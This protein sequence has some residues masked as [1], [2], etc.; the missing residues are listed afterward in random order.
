MIL[1]GYLSTVNVQNWCGH[2][3]LNSTPIW[4]QIE[5]CSLSRARDTPYPLDVT[6]KD[7]I[8]FLLPLMVAVVAFLYVCLTRRSWGHSQPKIVFFFKTWRVAIKYFY[9]P[10]MV[11]DYS[12]SMM[13][14]K[15]YKK[16]AFFRFYMLTLLKVLLHT[17]MT[18]YFW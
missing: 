15:K 4:P 18:G 11:Y 16:I 3:T 5:L 7:N 17:M 2:H 12:T 14:T 10:L 9:M 8:D 6:G 1:Q 13:N